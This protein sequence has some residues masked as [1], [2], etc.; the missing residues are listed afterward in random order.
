MT[1]NIYNNYRCGSGAAQ[2]LVSC[3]IMAA[4]LALS[5]VLGT[6]LG[7][8]VEDDAVSRAGDDL[9]IVGVRHELCTEDV[10]SMT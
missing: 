6:L 2:H 4:E 1:H 3:P 9:L 5:V 8:R 7:V 10:C